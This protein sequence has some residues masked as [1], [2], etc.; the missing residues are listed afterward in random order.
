MSVATF[1]YQRH[2]QARADH[3]AL[4]VTCLMRYDWSVKTVRSDCSIQTE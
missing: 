3:D 1:N 4:A 2:Q